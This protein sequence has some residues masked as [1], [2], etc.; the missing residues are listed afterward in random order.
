[1]EH[2]SA[3]FFSIGTIGSIGTN[4]QMIYVRPSGVNILM[5]L[6]NSVPIGELLFQW[7]RFEP[8][9]PI[10]NSLSHG[11]QAVMRCSLQMVYQWTEELCIRTNGANRKTSLTNGDFFTNGTSGEGFLT[12]GICL[13]ILDMC[14]GNHTFELFHLY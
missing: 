11:S 6:T 12:I 9:V 14:E 1:M 4:R 5:Q 2:R 10:D 7:N 13:C 8:M 3:A